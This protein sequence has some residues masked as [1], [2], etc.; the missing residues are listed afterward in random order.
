MS[1]SHFRVHEKTSNGGLFAR[2]RG[3]MIV[4]PV[5]N[6]ANPRKDN[7]EEKKKAHP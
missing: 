2:A 6:Q 1:V 4:K 3:R 5:L 7:K